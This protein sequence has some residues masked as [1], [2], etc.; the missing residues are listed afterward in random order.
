MLNPLGPQS[1]TIHL[2][3]GGP[4]AAWENTV[5]WHW[6]TRV[7]WARAVVQ[8]F[9]GLDGYATH[10]ERLASLVEQMKNNQFDPRF[11]S[12]IAP[13]DDRILTSYYA[14]S[15]VPPGG[16]INGQLSAWYHYPTGTTPPTPYDKTPGMI[17]NE[18]Q[19]VGATEYLC[20]ERI[21]YTPAPTLA[22]PMYK[23]LAI[24]GTL[25]TALW[26]DQYPTWPNWLTQISMDWKYQTTWQAAD[27]S[28]PWPHSGHWIRP[29]AKYPPGP[30]GPWTGSQK[31]NISLD[32]VWE[33]G[34]KNGLAAGLNALGVSIFTPFRLPQYNGYNTRQKRDITTTL[35]A[36]QL[37]L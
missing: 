7:R 22:A 8:A 16:P 33:T 25:D 1:G 17:Y 36:Y 29:P 3:G 26:A 35:T 31:I 34:Y 20:W 9:P 6:Q 21:I 18:A 12:Q 5:H 32:P 4:N 13:S 23:P 11:W 30:S 10:G 24:V 28:F 27:Y 19:G 37:A 2:P 15:P 14:S